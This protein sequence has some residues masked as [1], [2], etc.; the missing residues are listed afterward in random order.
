LYRH[1]FKKERRTLSLNVNI[2]INNKTGDGATNSFNEFYDTTTTTTL[3]SLKNENTSN[4]YTLGGNISYT[5]PIGK[6]GQVSVSYNPSF[7]NNMADKNT[8]SLV[9]NTDQ[10]YIHDSLLSNQIENTYTT[11]RGELSYRIGDR[12]LNFS[13]GVAGQYA[14][15]EG[16]QS[17]PYTFAINKDFKNVLPNAMFNYRFSQSS[18]LRIFYRTSTNA[19][20]ISQLQD[21]VDISNPILLRSGNPDLKQSYD[22]R[23]IFRYGN[24]NT[25]TAN[26]FFFFANGNY[27]NDYIATETIIPT[28]D[29]TFNGVDVNRG[30]QISRPVN[31]SGYFSGRT[32][33]TYGLPVDLIKSNLN[34]NAGFTYTHAPSLLNGQSNFSNS[35]TINGGVVISSNISENLD[36]TLSY[37]ANY[38]SVRNTLQTQSNTNYFNHIAGAKVNWIFYKRFVLNTSLNQNF[39]S[40]LSDATF[41]QTFLQWNA[42]FAYKLLKNNALE[43]RLSAFDILNQNKSITRNTTE[44]YFEDVRTQVLIQYFMLTATYTLRNFKSGQPQRPGTNDTDRERFRPDGPGGFRPGGGGPPPGGMN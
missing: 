7:T 38:N 34:L 43:L 29:T 39:F 12:K 28:S 14:V 19:P 8:D 26:S 6:K 44:T 33:A 4:S 15:L 30:S 10:T 5:E 37:N 17:E 27:T 18:N 40:G 22:H 21:V 32:F 20:S 23:L 16:L 35:S 36:F 24:T 31:L 42:Y 1:K 11:H 3:L 9:P 13:V 41:N 25:K 2:S